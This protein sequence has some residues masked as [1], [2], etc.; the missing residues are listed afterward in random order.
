MVYSSPLMQG[1][2]DDLVLFVDPIENLYGPIRPPYLLAK[3]FRDRYNVLIVSPVVADDVKPV[4]EE[5]AH[6]IDLGSYHLMR[7]SLLTLEFWFRRKNIE[8]LHNSLAINFSQCFL[9]DALVY[10][11]QGPI[12]TAIEEIISEMNYLWRGLYRLLRVYIASRDR[13]YISEI[14]RRSLLFIANSHASSK[15]YERFRIS[16]DGVIYPPIDCNEFKPTTRR[17]SEDYIVTYLGKETRLSVIKYLAN[18]GVRVKAFGTKLPHLFK[19]L[20][21]HENIEFL[22]EVSMKTLV[23]LYSNALFTLFTFTHEPFGYVPVESMACGTPVLTY[24]RE[25]PSETVVDGLTGWVVHSDEE[26]INR[27]LE[28]WRNGYPSSMRLQARSR[29][30]L[31]DISNIA[32]LW[33]STIELQHDTF[34]I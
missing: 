33:Y 19:P 24:D 23:D 10:Y 30:L 18:K 28:I 21:G 12:S 34:K 2:F 8:N 31:F 20:R 9:V 27:A 17:P 5:C 32:R 25:G 6:V 29:A 3:A 4:L 15:M 22:G 16:V 11:A 1:D 26:L 7:G 14:R 13:D